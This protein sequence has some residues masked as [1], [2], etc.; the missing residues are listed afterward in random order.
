MSGDSQDMVADLLHEITGTDAEEVLFSAEEQMNDLGVALQHSAEAKFLLRALLEMR[1]RRDH[2]QQACAFVFAEHAGSLAGKDTLLISALDWLCLHVDDKHLP[3]QFASVSRIEVVNSGQPKSSVAATVA[4]A[5]EGNNSGGGHAPNVAT[6]QAAADLSAVEQQQIFRLM[7]FGF[8]RKKITEALREQAQD[9]EMADEDETLGLLLAGILQR[10]RG[11]KA[12]AADKERQ[13]E[14]EAFVPSRE[15][16]AEMWEEEQEALAGIFDDDLDA[17]SCFAAPSGR[18]QQAMQPLPQLMAA[19]Q[20]AISLQRSKR[21]AWL[22]SSQPIPNI[23]RSHRWSDSCAA[24]CCQ[25]PVS[26]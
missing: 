8:S 10:R 14:L 3:R 25:R 15:E 4:L 6:V 5:E 26:R 19:L 7:S 11:A 21:C 23:Q 12:A 16:L 24:H 18:Q 9:R 2:A 13:A 20:S 22:S 1:F 17:R